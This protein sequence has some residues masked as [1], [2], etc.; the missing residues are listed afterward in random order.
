M[1]RFWHAL[2]AFVR[3]VAGL[4]PLGHDA[5]TVRHALEHRAEN[6]KSCC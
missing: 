6:R 1:K 5:E 2:R 3:G 4:G